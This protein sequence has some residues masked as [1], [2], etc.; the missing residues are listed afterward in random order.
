M[1]EIE[2]TWRLLLCRLRYNSIDMV[3][4]QIDIISLGCSKNLVDS[5]QLMRQLTANGY[6]AKHDPDQ[7]EGE[8]VVVNTCG[9]IGDAKEESINMILELCEAKK[10]KRIKQLIVM[11]CLSERYMADLEGELPDVDRFYGKF[12]W[13]QVI[14][15]LGKVYR[16]DL[17]LERVL[18]TPPHFAFIKIAEGCNRICS[19]CAIPIITGRYQS[20]PMEEIEQEIRLLV[21]EGVKE[22]QIIAQ[23]LSYYG[24]DLYK[25]LKLAE[26][27][28]RISDIPGVEWIRLHYA[29]PSKFPYDVLR[30][31]RERANV[32][33]YMDIA[34]Q[35]ITDNM[36][37]KMRRHANKEQ[38]LELLRRMREEVPGIHIRTT[39]M[40]GH[41]GET[42][43]DFEELMAFVKEAKF[44]RM[45]AFTY[46]EEEGT[47]AASEY[48]DEI[49][50]E[51][52]QERLDAIMRIQ[53]RVAAESNASK[54]GQTFKVIIDK[55]EG[56]YYVG[57]TEF[58]SPE[59][60]PE[61]LIKKEQLLQ[62]G[63]FYQVYITSAETFELFG[64]VIG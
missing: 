47:Y 39:L 51:V 24:L 48:T 50:P 5:E 3:K 43:A 30:V 35:H 10:A 42:E 56:D 60:D 37:S 21:S 13:K 55:E 28:E 32:C 14:E 23:D 38:T 2:S 40:V 9:F 12:N 34:L 53:E 41:P 7:V 26:L 45:G 36:L 49:E 15:D 27:I 54:V 8:I 46:S 25:E 63:N 4:N 31:M 11:G 17:K 59:V 52:K 58:D 64:E 18:T 61:V 6:T 16:S 22:F 62:I 19:F 44:E 29:Y 20:R 1:T 33:S 57:R